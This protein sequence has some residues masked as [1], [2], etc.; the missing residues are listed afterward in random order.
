MTKEPNRLLALTQQSIKKKCKQHV[1]RNTTQLKSNGHNAGMTQ[2][3][4]K[5][6]TTQS[7]F[8]YSNKLG[9]DNRIMQAIHYMGDKYAVR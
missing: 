5:I 7:L 1:N 3:C 4:R 9:M 2:T 8:K 6:G